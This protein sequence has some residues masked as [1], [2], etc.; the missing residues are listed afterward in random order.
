MSPNDFFSSDSFGIFL[1]A[2]VP[3]I[4]IAFVYD[5]FRIKRA[6]LPLGKLVLFFDDILF[7]LFSC[8]LYI[9]YAYRVNFGILRWY[10]PLTSTFVFFVWK[11]FIGNKIVSVINRAASAIRSCLK[12]VLFS[13]LKPIAKLFKKM[14]KY[15]CSVLCK[16]KKFYKKQKKLFS[17]VLYWC[18]IK[19][20]A[21]HGFGFSRYIRKGDINFK[22]Q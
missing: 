12:K 14:H 19:K 11:T 10:M 7:M 9:V 3:G 8:A 17:F 13:L 5:L 1:S 2:V 15:L 22:R 18:R 20:E 6:I 4:I 21:K 16:V